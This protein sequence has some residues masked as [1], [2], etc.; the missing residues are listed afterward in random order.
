MDKPIW[1]I[2]ID[3][4]DEHDI[5]TVNSHYDDDVNIQKLVETLFRLEIL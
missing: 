2:A 5:L 1:A 3:Y 4:M